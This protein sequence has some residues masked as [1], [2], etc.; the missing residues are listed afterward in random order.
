[1]NKARLFPSQKIHD[2]VDCGGSSVPV[3]IQDPPISQPRGRPSKRARN[4]FRGNPDF[5][6]I[7]LGGRDIA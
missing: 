6:F 5:S 4:S 3:S 1:M 2:F 7:N